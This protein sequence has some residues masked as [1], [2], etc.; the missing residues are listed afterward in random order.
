MKKYIQKT[1]ETCEYFEYKEKY[2]KF[3]YG[4]CKKR[5]I[6]Y[7]S[8]DWQEDLYCLGFIESNGSYEYNFDEHDD[9]LF[10]KKDAVHGNVYVS[11]IYNCEICGRTTS[12]KLTEIYNGK[13]TPRYKASCNYVRLCNYCKPEL[14]KESY[15]KLEYAETRILIKKIENKIKELEK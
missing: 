8:P 2:K 13:M 12:N 1:C 10:V 5:N 14:L 15:M 6:D 4:I 11:E 3:K 7:A 9:R